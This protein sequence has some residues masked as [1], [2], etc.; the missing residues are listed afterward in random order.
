MRLHRRIAA[1][2]GYDLVRRA[3]NHG[4]LH[5]HL[6]VLFRLERIDLVIDVGANAG[7]YATSLRQHGYA[8]RI[9]SFEPVPSCFEQL[10]NASRHDRNWRVIN[11]ALGNESGTKRMRATESTVYSSFLPFNEY[12]QRRYQEAIG[13]ETEVDVQVARLDDIYDE[14]SGGA[15][16]V[17]LKMDTQGY[18]LQVFNGAR[19]CL[20]RVAALQSEMSII[21]IYHGMPEYIEAL[22]TY[23]DAGFEPS[24]FYPVTRDNT[25]LAI[26]EFDGVLVRFR[27]NIERPQLHPANGS[28]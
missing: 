19:R 15:Q 20:S 24:G 22:K 11:V 5:A 3:K 7:Q 1:I 18:D 14:I 23:R 17:F 4:T 9:V 12:G 8:G 2:F 13:N 28:E 10:R 26:V 21:S 25:T 27:R 6:A 16:R